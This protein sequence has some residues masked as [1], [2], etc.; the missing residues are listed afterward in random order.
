MPSGPAASTTASQSRRVWSSSSSRCVRQESSPM[1]AAYC[2]CPAHRPGCL[3]GAVGPG[4]RTAPEF[5][6]LGPHVGEV[7][8]R[9][10]EG[11][12]R[13]D[14]DQLDAVHDAAEAD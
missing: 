3:P 13:Q 6:D 10:D 12:D 1:T 2:P 4:T 5:L 14:V 11:H 7:D 8:G 9:G